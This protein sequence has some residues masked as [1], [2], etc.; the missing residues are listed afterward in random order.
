[1]FLFYLQFGFEHLLDWQGY[2]HMLFL[3]VL[4][5]GYQLADW[6]RV[7]VLVTAF[8]IGHSVTLGMGAL[9]ITLLPSSLVEFLIP[10]TI[11]LTATDAWIHRSKKHVGKQAMTRKYVIAGVFGL[12]HGMGFSSQ[13]LELE[14]EKNLLMTWLPFNLGIELGQIL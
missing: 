1:M 14:A 13:F 9:G 2:D 10:V 8:T 5:A 3:L 12:I 6:R 4:C 11:F 7:L